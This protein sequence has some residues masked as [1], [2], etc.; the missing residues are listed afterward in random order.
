[1]TSRLVGLSA[2]VI[3]V[4]AVSACGSTGGSGSDDGKVSVAAAFY[5]LEYAV[6]QIGG[7]HVRVQA[8]TKPG[9][10]PHDLE[11]NPRQV[12]AVALADLVVY[13]KGFQPAVDDAVRSEAPHT[14][15]DVAPAARL[16][17]LA[18][19]DGHDHAGESDQQHSD[20]AGAAKD[21][22]FWLDP[23][24]YA[25]VGDAIATELGK[26]DAANAAAYTAN[27]KAFRAQLTTL[28]GE[29]RAGLRSCRIKDLVT[30]HAAFGYLSEAY[31]LTQESISG[32]TPDTEPSPSALADLSAHVRES[33][34]TTVYA[35]TLVSEDVAKTLSRETG[36]RLAVLDPIEG[37]TTKSAGQDYP[38]VM[39]A[40]LATL[41]AGQECS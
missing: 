31:G 11:L 21:P 29:F 30:S 27:A 23:M 39:R 6:S 9:A 38:S 20:H 10:E 19:G 24:R 16:D 40:N 3:A 28:D 25:D 41:E 1:M 26:R 5:P 37:I 33:G 14:A 34:A 17:L 36:A 2:A 13:E 8:L 7:D 18:T 15:F 35:E 4:A 22:H 32:L 12:G